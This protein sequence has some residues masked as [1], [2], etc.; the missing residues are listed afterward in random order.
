[1][2][3][4]FA[5]S[6]PTNL[7]DNNYVTD[8]TNYLQCSVFAR[9]VFTTTAARMFIK[10]WNTI[11]SAFPAWTEITIIINGTYYAKLEPDA[12]NG[13]TFSDVVLPAGSKIVEL[14]VGTQSKPAAS[15]IGTFINS[16]Y[17][18]G[19]VTTMQTPTAPN[20][21]VYGDSITAGGNADIPASES[22]VAVLRNSYGYR[23]A[24]EAWGYRSLFS[25]AP[26]A[27]GRTALSTQLAG[28]APTV[29]VWLAIGLNDYHLET[30]SAADFGT[31]YAD[32]LDKLH[33][34]LPTATIYCQLP[35]TKTSEVA[36]TF[37]DT[38]DDYRAAI[39][40]AQL[41][42]VAYA[43][44][45]PEWTVTLADGIHP[46]IAGHATFAENVNA[47]LSA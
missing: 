17:F 4:T 27:A 26:D 21:V 16:V 19:G 13:A 1:M 23:L 39:T 25:D 22:W 35:I 28:Y 29:G 33:T 6:S 10:T 14:V 12:L 15:V 11:Y 18:S 5:V 34:D 44:L 42:R 31:A 3:S 38:L 43:V 9:W 24:V 37:G 2:A 30:Q 45:V 20:Y 32:L 7:F 8:Q 47:I 41:S 36:N 46:T 40:T